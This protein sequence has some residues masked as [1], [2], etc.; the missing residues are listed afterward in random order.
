C[1]ARSGR[2][3]LLSSS[4]KVSQFAFLKFHL[5]CGID[6]VG[7][8]RAGWVMREGL[9]CER[10]NLLITVRCAVERSWEVQKARSGLVPVCHRPEVKEHGCL[11]PLIDFVGF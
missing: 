10:G 4:L 5:D 9:C 6:V 3:C 8:T 1:S 11:L 7:V 2:G